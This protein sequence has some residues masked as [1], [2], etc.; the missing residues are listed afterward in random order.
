[1]A[2]ATASFPPL[3]RTRAP[4]RGPISAGA[5]QTACG[6][7]GGGGVTDGV[8]SVLRAVLFSF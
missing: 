5:F 8:I 1:M 3:H 2:P 7:R 6:L 4:A